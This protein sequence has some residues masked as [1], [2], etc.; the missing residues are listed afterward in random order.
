MKIDTL[1]TKHEPHLDIFMFFSLL[2]LAI[3]GI[4]PNLILEFFFYSVSLL[5]VITTGIWTIERFFQFLFE[6]SKLFAAK[7]RWIGIF[8]EKPLRHFHFAPPPPPPSPFSTGSIIA[9]QT[10]PHFRRTVILGSKQEVT[11]LVPFVK[12]LNNLQVYHTASIT[13]GIGCSKHR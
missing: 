5:K 6:I 12:W 11:K 3:Y 10:K 4:I 8:K 9:N 2:M 13:P 7:L 1:S